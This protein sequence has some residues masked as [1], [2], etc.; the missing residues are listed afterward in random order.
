MAD[1]RT[2]LHAWYEAQGLQ[3]LPPDDQAAFALTL[4]REAATED[5]LAGMILLQEILIPSGAPGWQELL[6]AFAGL[7][8][9][10][11]LAD[12]NSAD[13]FCVKVLGPLTAREGEACARALGA[14]KKSSNL[15]QRRA[16]AVGFVNLVKSDE[17]YPGLRRVALESCEALV[18]SP[19]RFA[20][21]GAAWVLRE[22]SRADPQVVEDF[23]LRNL[24][25]M[26]REAAKNAMKYLP[27]E[28]R[29]ALW[30]LRQA[31]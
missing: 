13:W 22:M 16:S 21:T 28:R 4:L 14:W 26:S 30:K 18:A 25:R 10:G 29:Q 9:E 1:V 24:P 2:E 15:W 31:R 7:F 27:E 19:E 12:W 17:R 20:Q 6:P 3:R 23:L 11:H 5:K 8:R